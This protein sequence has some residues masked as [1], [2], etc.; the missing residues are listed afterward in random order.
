MSETNDDPPPFYDRHVF[1]CT[2]ER[3]D[4]HPRGCCKAKCSEKIRNYMKARA[5]ELGIERTRINSAGCLDRCELGPAVV[6]Y[7]E[8]VW[9]KCESM[10]DADRILTEHL[11]GGGRVKNLMLMPE[12]K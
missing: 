9:Y 7:P 4:G 8:G 6:I 11:L 2:N 3:P 12:D 5:K 10:A 1:F